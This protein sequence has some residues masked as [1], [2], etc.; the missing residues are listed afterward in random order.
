MKLELY[1]TTP[2]ESIFLL[3]CLVGVTLIICLALYLSYRYKWFVK[4]KRLKEEM[5]SLELNPVEENILNGMIKRYR[6]NEPVDLLMSLPLFDEL[7]EKEMRR[8]L[9]TPGSSTAKQS[10]IELVYEIRQRTFFPDWS[11]QQ[12]MTSV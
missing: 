1:R 6:L 10:Y 5:E 7:A 3:Q 9:K 2:I 11:H 4:F 12:D 8:V